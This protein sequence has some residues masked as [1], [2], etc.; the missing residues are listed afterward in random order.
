MLTTTGKL[1][2]AVIFV[3]TEAQYAKLECSR[4]ME[5]SSWHIPLLDMAPVTN[6]TSAAF[7]D[8]DADEQ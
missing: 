4:P 5:R 6:V 3:L 7:I 2:V 8:D 1:V